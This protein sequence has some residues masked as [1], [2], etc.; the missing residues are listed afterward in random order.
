VYIIDS[1]TNG[2][3]VNS[4]PLVQSTP[5]L[6]HNGDQISLVQRVPSADAADA[7]PAQSEPVCVRRAWRDR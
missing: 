5:R 2:T 7:T 1:S 4:H 6:L 3:Y